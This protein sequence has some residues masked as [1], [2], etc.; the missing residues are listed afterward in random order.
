MVRVPGSIG[1]TVLA[2]LAT[3]LLVACSAGEPEVRRARPVG[4]CRSDDRRRRPHHG[5]RDARDLAGSV[6]DR[7]GRPG[8]ALA[9]DVTVDEVAVF[10]GVKISV[11]ADG[12]TVRRGTHPSSRT[13]PCSS[14]CTSRRRRRG[15]RTRLTGELRLTDGAKDLLVLTDSKVISATSMDDTMASTFNFEVPAD[16]VTESLK[17]SVAIAIRKRRAATLEAVERRIPEGRRR[18]G[19][20][21]EVDR[22]GTHHRP[23]PRALR[24]RR[25]ET[26]PRHESGADRTLRST[27]QAMYPT[28]KVDVSV[29]ANVV[30]NEPVVGGDSKAA[31]FLA[32]FTQLRENDQVADDVYYYGL[33]LPAETK[34]LHCKEGCIT[35]MCNL[36]EKAGDASMRA[37]IGV[38]YTGMESAETMAHEL[39]HAHGRPH[40][41]CGA[42]TTSH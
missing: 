2:S 9:P 10:Q 37:C 36:V 21:C 31:R 20:R 16:V 27:L 26:L 23:R 22:Q 39:G 25:L 4:A 12:R 3:S 11:A 15:S 6:G 29:H 5:R 14:A 32:G 33:F 35:G 24:R 8:V 13:A 1:L 28:S 19:A 17:W 38:G 34:A 30:W 40:S 7:R 18:R 41:P 42:R